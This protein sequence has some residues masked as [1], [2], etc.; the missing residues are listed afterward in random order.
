VPTLDSMRADTLVEADLQQGQAD[1]L[2]VER[3][4]N[5]QLGELW[6]LIVQAY[7][8]Y[9]SASADFTLATGED[10][11]DLPIDF[12]QAT[13]LE[14]LADPTR[15]VSLGTFEFKDRN[16]TW[17]AKRWCVHGGQVL[18]RP[19]SS[20]PGNYRLTYV[21]AFQDLNPDDNFDA[22]NNWHVYAVLGVAIRLR[23]MQEL[24]AGDLED[25]RKAVA[26][27]IANAARKRQG[28]RRVRDVRRRNVYGRPNLDDW[29]Y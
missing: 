24:A 29:K 25:R 19:S 15:P 28:P 16:Q 13:D 12:Y 9:Y 3:M 8:G 22:P 17:G 11:E 21:P 14:D 26:E 1:D 5:E 2:V 20:A 7:E 4:L 23:S 6:E 18:V 27:R 10:A